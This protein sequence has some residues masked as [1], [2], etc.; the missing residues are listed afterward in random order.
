MKRLILLGAVAGAMLAWVLP[1]A[2]QDRGQWSAVSST[3]KA[4]TGDISISDSRLMIN[5]LGFPIAPIRKLEPAEVNSVFVAEG[6]GGQGGNLYRLGISAT[7]RFLHK[8][9]LCGSEDTVWMV[10]NVSGKS[11]QV[12]FL[13]GTSMP[14]F[15]PEAMGNSTDLCGTFSYAR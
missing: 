6:G 3:A 2:A 10:T 12:A 15:T 1:G 11:L 7:Q 9:S 8:N 5:L 13:S 14:V 4:I